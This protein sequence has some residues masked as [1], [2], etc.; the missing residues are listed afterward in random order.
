[1]VETPPHLGRDR[2]VA[3]AGPLLHQ[4]SEE[5]V[6]VL[7]LRRVQSRQVQVH[8]PLHQGPLQLR[9]ELDRLGD[10]QG[11]VAGL[12]EIGEELPHL[13][14]RLHVELLRVELEAIGVGQHLPR[15]LDAE[16]DVVGAG[17]GALRVVGV[18]GGDQG[19]PEVAGDP[20][21]GGVHSS[22]VVE[23]VVL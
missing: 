14:G 4:L 10:L 16:Q 2:A 20:H 9:D 18:V 3:A 23:A 11:G 13:L 1:M 12:R 21:Q 5:G 15:L 8:G 7:P 22:L 19:D 6:L 17:V